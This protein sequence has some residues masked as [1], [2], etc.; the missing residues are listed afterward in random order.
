[1]REYLAHK[2]RVRHD[3]EA[4][5]QK[6]F[7]GRPCSINDLG[8]PVGENSDP[9]MDETGYRSVE[10]KGSEGEQILYR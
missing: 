10:V 9:A 2:R 5:N 6:L 4:Q 3:G 8:V 7:R 1:M